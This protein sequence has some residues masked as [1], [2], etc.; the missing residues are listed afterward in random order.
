MG[1]VLY[2]GVLEMPDKNAAANRV[3]ANG[4]IFSCLGY[5]TVYLGVSSDITDRNAVVQLSENVY[6]EALITSVKDWFVRTLAMKNL[7]S[8][9]EKYPDLRLVIAYNVPYFK[10]LQIKAHFEKKGVAVAYD[11]TEWS[12]Y[13]KGT[14]LKQAIKR[15]DEKLIENRLGDTA[16]NLIVISRMME[17][18]YA[19][20]ANIVN[21]PPMVDT[22][23]P[24]W[25]KKAAENDGIFEFCFAGSVGGS[26]E[27]PDVIVKAFAS[28]EN[29]NT[30]LRIVGLTSDDYLAFYPGDRE[31]VA[32]LGDRIV[33][34]GRVPHEES[35]GYIL[36]CGCYIFIRVSDKRNNA[37]FP[38]KFVEA[39]TCGVPLITTN[40]SDIAD[41]IRT[42]D[43]VILLESGDAAS[44]ADAMRK[45]TGVKN[46]A[47]LND[48]F[49]YRNYVERSRTW[50]GNVK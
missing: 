14:S 5:D 32:S 31:L 15:A 19:G 46:N 34:T 22:S 7:I 2:Y 27:S 17:Q 44:V 50:L 38:T 4:K 47:C 28:L 11:C 21:L 43:D 9:A 24:I 25:R 37:G 29:K 41:Y 1:T 42:R 20:K 36:G 18:K 45:I 8:V 48:A 23:D 10:F 13:S 33:F 26:K 3:S 40:V 12:T 49:D 6:A 39:T 16:D 30:R 35:V